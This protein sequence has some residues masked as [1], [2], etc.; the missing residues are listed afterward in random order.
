MIGDMDI[1]SIIEENRKL[2]KLK[3]EFNNI[4]LDRLIRETEAIREMARQRDQAQET[5]RQ[6][7]RRVQKLE[8]QLARMT[9]KLEKAQSKGAKRER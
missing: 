7:H 5:C 2:K 4:S 9:K 8:S 6:L 1:N 3:E